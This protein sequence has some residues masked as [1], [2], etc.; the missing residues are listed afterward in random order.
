M[1]HGR[2]AD[3]PEHEL[4]RSGPQA[5]QLQRCPLVRDQ[6]STWG[7]SWRH[8][9]HVYYPRYGNGGTMHHNR[10]AAA[11]AIAAVF[12]TGATQ[13]AAQTSDQQRFVAIA[14]QLQAAPLNP[15]LTD[16]REWAVAWLSEA[17]DITVNLCPAVLAGWDQNNYRY[18][19]Q[20]LF[21]YMLSMGAFTIAHPEAAQN[22]QAQQL[23][24][25]EATLNAYR[26]IL[27]AHPE[28]R[29]P[30]LEKLLAKK[31]KGSLSTFVEKARA[32]C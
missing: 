1:A 11:V 19:G 32:R 18:A 21:A 2:E 26:A 22:A 13:S 9:P 5:G 23:V 15:A 20:L 10:L 8:A 14:E 17:P 3:S 24:G 28:A 27:V 29:S 6:C 25:V 30:G 7:F 31:A 16:E 4:E 12:F